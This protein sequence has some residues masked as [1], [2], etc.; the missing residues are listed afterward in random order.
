MANNA[1]DGQVLHA[2]EAQYHIDRIIGR[3]QVGR[4]NA[5]KGQSTET[6]IL[7]VGLEIADPCGIDNHRDFGVGQ[8]LGPKV[9]A[10]MNNP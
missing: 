1:V 4:M 7:D 2:R 5:A 9:H 10:G 8:C 6:D 3:Q